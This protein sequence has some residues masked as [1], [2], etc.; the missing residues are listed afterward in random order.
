MARA[1]ARCSRSAITA[2]ERFVGSMRKETSTTPSSIV[3]STSK[4]ASVNTLIIFAF[5][6]STSAVKKL[7]PRSRAAAARCSSS[8]EASPAPWRASDTLNATSAARGSMRSYR[9]TAMISSPTST[10]KAT[11]SWWS[12]CVN[13]D[14]SRGESCGI[15]A[16]KR[17]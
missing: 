9:A 6:G 2:R 16:K 5:C 10:M 4:P 1:S 3:R 13:R 14:R 7:I 8:T 17:R 12:T 11:R 15:A